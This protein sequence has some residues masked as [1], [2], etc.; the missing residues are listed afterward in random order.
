MTRRLFLAALAAAPVA[1]AGCRNGGNVSLFGYTT[2]PPF[3]PNVRS[4]Y[5]PTFKMAPVVATPF[6]SLDVE[7]TDAVVKELAKKKVI[8]RPT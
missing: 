6:R 7:L 8:T 3:D 1:L 2:E 4:V 5:V